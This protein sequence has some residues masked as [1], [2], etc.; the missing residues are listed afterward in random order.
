MKIEIDNAEQVVEKKVTIFGN[1][2]K[3][4]VPKSWINRKVQVVLLEE[5]DV[6]DETYQTFRIEAYGF[7][8]LISVDWE[9]EDVLYHN[10]NTME[11]V[12]DLSQVNSNWSYQD[13]K[14]EETYNMFL[15]EVGN[16]DQLLEFISHMELNEN[17]IT[18]NGHN[19]TR[20]V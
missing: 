20:V 5:E 16:D 1:G 8:L 3:V 10:F 6:V 13:E 15:S 17:V 12:E 19:V 14:V 7:I 9:N 2:A 4:N 11:W 18:L